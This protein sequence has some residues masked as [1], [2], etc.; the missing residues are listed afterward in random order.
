M[1]FDLSLK[2]NQSIL[3]SKTSVIEKDADGKN[4][5]MDYGAA[6]AHFKGTIP[7]VGLSIGVS[8][9]NANIGISFN[10]DAD[11]K[12]HGEIEWKKILPRSTYI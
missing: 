8:G 7:S 4:T 1:T 3:K 9:K 5:L 10:I 12:N 11:G 2:I 6:Y